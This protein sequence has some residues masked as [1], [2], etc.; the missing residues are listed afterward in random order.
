M[1]CDELLLRLAMICFIAI[2][3]SMCICLSAHTKVSSE[4]TDHHNQVPADHFK[5]A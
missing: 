2:V 1:R 5:C 4:T 3:R